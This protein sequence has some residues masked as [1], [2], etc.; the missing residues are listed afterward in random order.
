MSLATFPHAFSKS[1]Q[2]GVG[3]AC[4]ILHSA[5]PQPNPNSNGDA[6]STA[7]EPAPGGGCKCNQQ[8]T[9]L[10]SFVRAICSYFDFPSY[11]K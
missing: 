3:R 11:S 7:E 8:F 4:Q 9:M 6:T 1:T 10:H 5:V 2:H